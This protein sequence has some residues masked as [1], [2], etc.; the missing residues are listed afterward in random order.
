MPKKQPTVPNKLFFSS[1]KEVDLNDVYGTRNKHYVVR[2]LIDTLNRYKFT[3]AENTAIEEEVALDPELLGKVF[4]NLLASYNPETGATA[5]KKTGSFYTP[6]EIVNYMVDESLIA[7]LETQL[8]SVDDPQNGDDRNVRLRQLLAYTD[9][10]PK[11]ST[12]EVEKLIASIDGVKILDPACGSGAFPMGILQKL[13]F[14]LSKLDPNNA[15]WEQRQI[16]RV[17]EAMLVA[18]RIEDHKFR[19]DTLH[20]LHAQIANIEE[21]F[22]RNELDYGRKLFLIENC[23][24]GIDI[25]AIAI[26]I[27]KLRFFIS[28]IIDQRVQPEAVNLGIRPLPNLETKFVAANTLLDI[29]GQITLRSDEIAAK[30]KELKQVREEHF[31]AR[32]TRRKNRL[33]EADEKLRQRIGGLIDQLGLVPPDV[34]QELIAW[35][36]YDQNKSA[37]FFDPEW[38][39]GVTDGFGIVIGNPPYVLLQ[40]ANREPEVYERFKK[41][42]TVAS[43]KVDLYHLFIEQGIRLLGNG[44]ILTYITP[45]NFVSNKHTV[46]LRRLLLTETSLTKL[47]FFEDNVFEASVNNLVLF[48]QKPSRESGKVAFLKGA[49]S[50][51][52]LD[53]QLQTTVQQ[54][55]LINERCLLI[56]PSSAEASSLLKK[57][58]KKGKGLGL[59]ASVNFGMQLRDRKEFPGDVIATGSSRLTKFHRPCYTGKDISRYVVNFGDRYCYFNREA[60]RGGCWDENIHSTKNKVLIPQIGAFPEAGLDMKGYAV[61][62]TAFMVVPTQKNLNPRFLVGLLNSSCIQFFWLNKFTD[63]RKTFPKIKGEYLKLIPVPGATAAQENKIVDYVNQILLASK[64]RGDDADTSELE[65]KIDKIVYDL[66]ELTSEERAIVEASTHR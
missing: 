65:R 49:L 27:A 58:E 45:S 44:G 19:E 2:G 25:Q 3:I 31:R 15:K 60:R 35:N 6:R 43:Y 17:R 33:R 8:A 16:D 57:M 38:M 39:F 21:A 29:K 11:F 13:V 48:A 7:Y 5:R 1:E 62:N 24:Y 9:D 53:V 23:I 32:T 64:G 46:A 51:A 18:E 61:L 54:D 40:D 26:Q 20:D 10:A 4:E 55:G 66:Y 12:E 56:P 52:G 37:D 59:I 28:L 47:L 14:I 41:N 63:D 36:P 42:F 22:A 30:E 34:T 50:S